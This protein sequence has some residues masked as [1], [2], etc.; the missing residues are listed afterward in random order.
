MTF[1]VKRLEG[2]QQR[3]AAIYETV[4]PQAGTTAT[5]RLLEV[6]SIGPGACYLYLESV[7]PWRRW[8]WADTALAGL[9][10]DQLAALHTARPTPAATGPLARWDYEADLLQ[11]AQSTLDVFEQ[12]ARQEY[13]TD[14][15]WARP[16]LRRI[17]ASLAGLRRALRAF[18]PADVVI[19]G[20]PHSGNALIRRR[21]ATKTA[22]LL[23]WGRAR[24]G[25]PLEDVSAWLQSL[26]LW[27]PAAQRRHD[28]LLRGYL[29]A[30][31]QTTDLRRELRDAYWFA[32]VSNV[33]AGALR[34]HLTILNHPGTPGQARAEAMH[35]AR[36]YLRIVR[37]ADFCWRR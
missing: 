8:P 30:R 7:Q 14:M 1:V 18:E 37:R 36:S 31:G 2:D 10:L 28:T 24:L 6:E 16:A 13:F 4:L 26:R 3:E 32:A 9:V 29:V 27:E 19:H 23:D 17:V 35:A 22:I 12:T 25:A 21:Q 33:L 11:S 34:Y 20:D 15:P 5:P